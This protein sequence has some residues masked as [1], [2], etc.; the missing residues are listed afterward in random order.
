VGG[1]AEFTI[2]PQWSIEAT[3]TFHNV[4]TPVDP[5]RFSA[6]HAGLRFRF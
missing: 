2:A 5:T 6:I 4:S 3:Y 1:V